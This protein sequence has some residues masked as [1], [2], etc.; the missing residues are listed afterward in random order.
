MRTTLEIEDDILEAAQELAEARGLSI[1]SEL[2]D[3][4]RKG[5]APREAKL[6]IRNGVP[7]VPPRPGESFVT[8]AMVNRLRDQ[9]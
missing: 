3:L 8:S 2:S 9:D 6:R 1:G 7:L 5:L 4:A